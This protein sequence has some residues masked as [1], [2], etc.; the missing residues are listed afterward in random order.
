MNLL[1]YQLFNTV[2]Y[3]R[4]F[5]WP[6]IFWQLS[7]FCYVAC[8]W[9]LFHYFQTVLQKSLHQVRGI[10]FIHCW[11]HFQHLLHILNMRFGTSSEED[12]YFSFYSCIHIWWF[13]V[14]VTIYYALLLLTMYCTCSCDWC[15]HY[16]YFYFI[17]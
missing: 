14:G 17:E 1:H 7:I 13:W 15:L 12:K 2:C 4:I 16:F 9:H 10:Y 6:Y 11:L 8:D 3:F 5:W